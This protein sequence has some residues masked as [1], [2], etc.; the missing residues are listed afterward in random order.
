MSVWK[1][2]RLSDVAT[3]DAADR[4]FT[5]GDGAFETMRFRQGAVRHWDRH[6]ARLQNSARV[7]NIPLPYDGP[8]LLAAIAD[9]AR[10]NGLTDG[11]VRLTLSRGPGARG[12]LPPADPHPTVL[13][14]M[15]PESPPLDA[16]RMTVSTLTRRNEFS[17][18]SAIKSLNYLDAILARQE[19]VARGFDDVILLNTAGNVA[20]SSVSSIF[21]VVDGVLCTPPVSD[22]ALPGVA[23]GLILERMGA[24][25]RS[26]TPAQLLGAAQVILTNVLGCRAVRE[27]D[28]TVL[29]VGD[30]A[31]QMRLVL[32]AP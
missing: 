28:G 15:A 23:R 2:G 30:W 7:L 32:D 9:V 24:I 17:P 22:G 14:G 3:I 20:E 18:L 10:S 11:V 26:M 13:V 12:L 29:A 21:A 25:E 16:A 27:I 8:H 6:L 31:S 19:A 4:G 5:L 1:N